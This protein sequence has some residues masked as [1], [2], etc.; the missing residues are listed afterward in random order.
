MES[1][2]KKA[3]NED[4]VPAYSMPWKPDVVEE[5]RLLVPA[6]P[7]LTDYKRYIRNHKE[8]LDQDYSLERCYWP[9]AMTHILATYPQQIPDRLWLNWYLTMSGMPYEDFPKHLDW[10]CMLHL[11]WHQRMNSYRR[12]WEQWF[13]SQYPQAGPFIPDRYLWTRWYAIVYA[14][15]FEELKAVWMHDAIEHMEIEQEC[16]KTGMPMT[17]RIA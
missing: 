10:R 4:G 12:T 16:R 1:L 3:V 15:G 11:Y 14:R 9:S 8:Q 17:R 2:V 13:S 5:L 7:Y 6:G